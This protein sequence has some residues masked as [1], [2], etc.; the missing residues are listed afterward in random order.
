MAELLEIII[1]WHTSEFRWFGKTIIKFPLHTFTKTF[2][3]FLIDYRPALQQIENSIKSKLKIITS[4]P[5]NPPRKPTFAGFFEKAYKIWTVAIY[6]AF[7]ALVLQQPFFDLTR[8]QFLRKD[9]LFNEDNPYIKNISLLIS[10]SP[11]LKSIFSIVVILDRMQH[12][13]KNR[14]LSKVPEEL[15][16]IVTNPLVCYLIV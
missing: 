1:I 10:L 9:Y 11:K 12:E 14:T 7:A 6:P 8:G 3:E 5:G 4:A 16:I 2:F 13:F 15:V